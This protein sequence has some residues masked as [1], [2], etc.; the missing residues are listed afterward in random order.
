[1]FDYIIIGAGFAGA[2][3]AER[4]A[5]ERNASV[6]LVEKRPHI[7]G[8]CYD[9]YDDHGV[10]IHE[11][12]PHLFH[13]SNAEVFHYLSRFTD[14]IE[15]QHRVLAVVDGQKVPL[16]FNLNALHRLFPASLADSLERKLIKRYGFDIKVPIL[17]LKKEEDPQLKF[18]ADFIYNKVFLKYTV[19]QWACPPEDI[20]PEVTARV[21][22]FISRDDHYFQD[23]YQVVPKHG[24]TRLFERLLGH[25]NIKLLLNTDYREIL[26]L[27]FDTAEIQLFG[28]SFSGHLIHTGMID[29]LFDYRFGELPYRSLKFRFEHLPQ[30]LFQEVTT[31]N[32]PENY[33]FTRITEFKHI[34]RQK[35]PGT[36]IVREYPQ[37]YDRLKNG[38]NIPY[39]PIFK[40]ENTARYRQYANFARRFPKITL[41]GRLAEYR[42][43]DMDD[44]VARALEVYRT[45]FATQT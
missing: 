8:N 42:Y 41:V 21:P 22:V 45:R 37:D 26:R 2:V 23:K 44:I 6:L 1:M 15:Y 13:T 10:L 40:D 19:K 7:G 38:R 20:A 14:W 43:Y 34:T 29:E 39:Y 5:S 12:G 24:Y 36:T 4:L 35:L 27:D 3:I 17:E 31:V 18:L 16:P 25:P 30:D 9:R 33:D 28:Q 32:Y 11:Y